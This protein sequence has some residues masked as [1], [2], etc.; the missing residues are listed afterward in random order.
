MILLQAG[1]TILSTA[2]PALAQD[3]PS[4]AELARYPAQSFQVAWCPQLDPNDP[5]AKAQHM[6]G[7]GPIGVGHLIVTSAKGWNRFLRRFWSPTSQA[8]EPAPSPVWDSVTVIAISIHAS[9]CGRSPFTS[10]TR[11]GSRLY[12][13]VNSAVMGPC[14]MSVTGV[15]LWWLRAPV[16]NVVFADSSDLGSLGLEKRIRF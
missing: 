10:V 2:C 3:M 5:V 4:S 11:R 16:G 7:F 8:V 9:G 12:V 15:F 14:D 13:G 6:D 1:L